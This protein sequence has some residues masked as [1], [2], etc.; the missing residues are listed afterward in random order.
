MKNQKYFQ[1]LGALQASMKAKVAGEVDSFEFEPLAMDLETFTRKI[2]EREFLFYHDEIFGDKQGFLPK[3]VTCLIAA[4][5]GSGKTYLLIQAAIAAATG[6]HWLNAKA[7]KPMKVLYLAAEEE[8][9]EVDRRAQTAAKSMGLMENPKL[10]NLA[11]SNLRIFGRIGKNERLMDDKKEPRD[12]FKKLKHFL[13]KHPDVELV[14]L[15][16]A[17]DYMSCEVEK[18]S[19]EAKDWIKLISELTM[20]E[21]RPTVL[22]AHHTRKDTKAGSQ[23]Y[24]A[25][26]KDLVPSM[27]ADDIRGSGSLVQGFR[28]AAV[29]DRRQYDD[30]SEKVFLQVVK[31]NY[32]KRSGILQN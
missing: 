11:A 5:G 18:D 29:L 15:D 30:N 13:K 21:G 7:T 2:P 28:W 12:V 22:V 14:I 6:G 24:K 16:P 17:S 3:G 23:I 4:P 26:E 1:K 10:L 19:A 25:C 9:D 20:L 27:N 8:Q 32:T 31:S